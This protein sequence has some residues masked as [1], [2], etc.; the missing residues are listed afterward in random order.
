[1]GFQVVPA[2]VVFH[3]PPEATATYQVERS[4]GSTV[5]SMMR[6]EV[7]AGPISRRAR[8]AKVSPERRSLG[9]SALAPLAEALAP[10]GSAAALDS[11]RRGETRTDARSGNRTARARIRLKVIASRGCD[12]LSEG[13]S[14][15]RRPEGCGGLGA[16]LANATLSPGIGESRSASGPRSTPGPFAFWGSASAARGAV[17]GDDVLPLAGVR[18]GDH[19]DHGFRVAQVAHLVRHAGLDEDEVARL[20]VDRQLETRPVLVAHAA[21]EDIEHDLEVDVHVG[22][23]D[24]AGRDGRHVHRQLPGG[25][26]LGREADL[27]ADAVPAAAGAA[28]THDEDAV[29]PLDRPLEVG[30]VARLRLLFCLLCHGNSSKGGASLAGRVG[31]AT[32]A[33]VTARISELPRRAGKVRGLSDRAR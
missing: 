20:V 17:V 10:L 6:P 32:G 15:G 9:L 26:V 8:P 13:W 31:S 33:E 3:T 24:A 25:D 7:N 2:L 16:G 28:A 18:A 11:A 5:T 30:G 27:V 1:M 14:T 21:L 23:G 29:A 19:G 22:E 12:S 4:R